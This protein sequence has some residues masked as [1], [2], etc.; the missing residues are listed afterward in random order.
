MFYKCT[1]KPKQDDL[2]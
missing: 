1:D 2:M